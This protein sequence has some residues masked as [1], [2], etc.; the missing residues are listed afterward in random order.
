MKE[1]NKFRTGK[2]AEEFFE[3]LCQ[4]LEK[5]SIEAEEYYGVEFERFR[6]DKSAGDKRFDFVEDVWDIV[7]ILNSLKSRARRVFRR[8]KDK[9]FFK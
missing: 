7:E 5:A 1:E 8:G 2:E 4:S 6:L 3:S 9:G